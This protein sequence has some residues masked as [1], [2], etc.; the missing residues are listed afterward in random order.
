MGKE[1][2]RED[3][4]TVGVRFAIKPIFCLATPITPMGVLWQRN[5]QAVVNLIFKIFK[6][7]I[8]TT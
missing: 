3:G 6:I 4:P 7:Y 5:C 2:E 1:F 8:L